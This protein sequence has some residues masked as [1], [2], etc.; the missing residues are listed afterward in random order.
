MTDYPVAQTESDRRRLRKW[1]AHLET[2]GTEVP[3]E[4]DFQT[5]G[6]LPTLE[7]LRNVLSVEAPHHCA[8]LMRVISQLKREKRQR[9]KP[10]RTTT[11]RRGRVSDLSVGTE[12]LPNDWKVTLIEMR[13][14]R[15]DLDG[16][17]IDL[18]DTS[19]PALSQIRA[20]EYVLRCIAKVCIEADRLVDLDTES[21]RFWLERQEARGQGETGLAMQLRKLGE[22]LRYRDEKGK[23]RK[24]IRGEASRF[25]RIGRLKR[26]R[27]H[28]WLLANPTD[29]G[30]VWSLAEELLAQ[31][32]ATKAG[33]SRR[34][35]LALHASALAL[36]VSAP[37]RVGDLSRF[38]IDE[39]V[40]RDATGWSI[41]VR[42]RKT[43]GEY[44]RSELWPELTEFLDELLVL[45]APGGDL[46]RGY[47]RRSGTPLFSRD[48]GVT[49]LTADWI[50][51]VWYEHVG[52]GEHIVRTL[53]H[54]LAYDS[55]VDRTWMALSLC[56]Q[57]GGGR[58]ASE[59]RDRNQR[60]RAVRAGRRSLLALRRAA[61]NG[62][63]LS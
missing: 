60:A 55:D 62:E 58:T 61:V 40:R 42:T 52:T 19:P 20:T 38:R 51:D 24:A 39:E 59:Y 27:K 34:Y 2:R 33:T 15:K 32:R 47:D 26:K 36:A 43:G 46:W 14:R 63:Q 5:F 29:I 49:A 1:Q 18:G 23:L 8:P 11:S 10:R 48:G 31:S 30:V 56:G 57:R 28:A 17:M 22:F 9:G 13:R 41:F 21:V 25:A 45:D 53:W 35:L 3:D 12:E 16:G 7:R 44:E 50:S 37:L 54:Q 6:S 4:K